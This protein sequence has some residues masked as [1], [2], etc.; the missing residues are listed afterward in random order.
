MFTEN[1]IEC[2]CMV[3]L[4]IIKQTNKQTITDPSYFRFSSLT[5]LGVGS[6][7][8]AVN[9]PEPKLWKYWYHEPTWL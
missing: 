6:M 9:I 1:L 2:L 7:V 4:E 8:V 3:E 5:S